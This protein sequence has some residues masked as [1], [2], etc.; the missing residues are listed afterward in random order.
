MAP[1]MSLKIVNLTLLTSC[2]YP[3]LGETDGFNRNQF[4]YRGAI[5]AADHMHQTHRHELPPAPAAVTHRRSVFLT[6]RHRSS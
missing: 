4:I 1:D 3:S 2:L 6:D 5:P